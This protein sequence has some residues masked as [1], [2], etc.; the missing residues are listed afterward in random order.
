MIQ[1]HVEVLAPSWIQADQVELFAN[2]TKV[3]EARLDP[4]SG[5]RNTGGKGNE[6]KVIWDIARSAHDFH[7]VAIAS[8]PG[9]IAPYWPI[10]RPYQPASRVWTPRVIGA[11]NPIWIDGDGDRKF[12]S[13]HTA[14]KQ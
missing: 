6:W 9:V 8:G 14:D 10:A 7:L 12:S 3:R 4:A 13:A 1:V 5:K 11:T 2:G